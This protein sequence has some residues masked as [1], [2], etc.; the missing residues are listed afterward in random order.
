MR[1][2]MSVAFCLILFIAA[3][4]LSASAQIGPMFGVDPFAEYGLS[5]SGGPSVVG[6][7]GTLYVATSS[8][9]WSLKSIFGST[10]SSSGKLRAI[11]VDGTA[12]KS[13]TFTGYATLLAI[14]KND[15]LYLVVGKNLY[16]IP[17]FPSSL[18]PQLESI[19][20]DITDAASGAPAALA[21]VTKKELKGYAISLKVKAVGE[22]EY[23]YVNQ[24][25]V[26]TE[27]GSNGRS[28]WK[29]TLSTVIFD[30]DGKNLREVTL[31]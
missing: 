10:S 6:S 9:S 29:V 2:R 31:D 20:V 8:L 24:S 19:A 12:D 22:K 13:V 11:K 16:F 14:G 30:S 26:T 17:T 28:T 4:P 23:V 25:Q 15:Q 1:R 27:K 3:L 7:D 5:I 18:E 21:S